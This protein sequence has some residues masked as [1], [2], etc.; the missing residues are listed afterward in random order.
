[1]ASMV[2]ARCATAAGLAWRSRYSSSPTS[3]LNPMLRQPYPSGLAGPAR[4]FSAGAIAKNAAVA[5]SSLAATGAAAGTPCP[6]H[7]KN[8]CAAHAV[9]TCLATAPRSADMSTVAIVTP[10][11]PPTTPDA[12][13]AGGAAATTVSCLAGVVAEGTTMIDRSIESGRM[14]GRN[15]V[16]D[17]SS[18]CWSWLR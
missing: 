14:R 7:R 16:G 2:L 12:A 1:M 3:P 10:P 6:T 13:A 15:G 5:A 18:G 4:C 11:P 8:P 17:W 9:A